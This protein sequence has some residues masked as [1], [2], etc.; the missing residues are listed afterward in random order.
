MGFWVGS[1]LDLGVTKG[2]TIFRNV[3]RVVM[4]SGGIG[5]WA[6][7]G[8]IDGATSKTLNQYEKLTV[9]SDGANW[10]VI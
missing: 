8:T 9:V 7:A 2:M 5:L 6:C 3:K 1:L 10:I 4:F